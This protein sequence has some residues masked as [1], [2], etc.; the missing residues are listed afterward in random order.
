MQDEQPHDRQEVPI[1]ERP[2]YILDGATGEAFDVA[3]EVEELRKIA[4]DPGKPIDERLEAYEDIIDSEVGDTAMVRARNIEREMGLRQIYLKFEGGNPTGILIVM[5]CSSGHNVK[6]TEDA[7]DPSA[8]NLPCFKI[9]TP[10]ATYFL[11][12]DGAGLSSMIDRDSIDWIGFD[13]GEGTGAGGEYRGFPNAVYK[14]D[15]SYFHP[16]NKGTDLSQVE[17][18]SN[19]GNFV[20]LKAV[21]GNGN[22][23]ALWRFYPS[24]CTFTMTKM[25]TGYHYWVLY[26]GIPGGEYDDT[27]WYMTSAIEDKIPLTENHEGDLQDPEWIALGDKKMDRTIVLFHHEDDDKIDRFYQMQQK[28]TVFGFGRNGMDRLLNSVPQSFSIGFVESTEHGKIQEF[29]EYIGKMRTS[30][31]E[32]RYSRQ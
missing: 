8:G 20:E 31:H 17:V 29:I 32:A 27:D 23:E 22:W 13:P 26:E 30:V 18:V 9:E 5:G 10:V 15:G 11:E 25:P 21:S 2:R 7:H 28:M 6:L 14:E 16:K 19:L 1:S 3:R 4:E 24:H 12:K